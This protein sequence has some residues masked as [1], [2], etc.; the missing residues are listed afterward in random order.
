MD[1]QQIQQFRKSLSVYFIYLQAWNGT[2]STVTEATYWPIIQALEDSDD[3][4]AISG[5]N[6]WQREPKYS[7]ETCRSG[8]LST[9]DHT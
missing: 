8:A 5:I 1:M 2:G 7:E 4:G 6:V 9:T 3:C